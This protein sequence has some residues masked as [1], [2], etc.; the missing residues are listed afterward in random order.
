MNNVF[1]RKTRKTKEIL[2]RIKNKDFSGGEGQAI[3]NSTWQ[4]A[5]TLTAKIGSL[6]FTIII[7]RLMLPEVY[8]LY[9]LAL[10]TILFMGVFNDFGISSALMTFVSKTIDKTPGKSKGISS[11]F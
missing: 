7:A 10:S 11:S 1:K 6:L 8:G 2:E 4:V 3:K 5:T 9:G